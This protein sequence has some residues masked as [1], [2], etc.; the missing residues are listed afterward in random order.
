MLHNKENPCHF[1]LLESTIDPLVFFLR[2]FLSEEFF[3]ESERWVGKVGNFFAVVAAFIFLIIGFRFAIKFDSFNS[4][5]IG[6]GF[7]VGVF[8]IQYISI[9]FV[10]PII[11]SIQNSQTAISDSSFLDII[12][13]LFFLS[14]LGA[15][16]VSIFFA[17]KSDTFNLVIIGFGAFFST[18][19][20]ACLYLNPSLINIVVIESRGPAEDA[21]GVI[22]SF[23]KVTARSVVI[24]Y[25]SW[26]LIGSICLLYATIDVFKGTSNPLELLSY[27]WIFGAGLSYPIIA[28]FSFIF[29]MLSIQLMSTILG[30]LPHLKSIAVLLKNSQN[31]SNSN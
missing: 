2:E 9:K 5:L 7:F 31:N 22:S 26:I 17:V 21:L 20:A 15:L 19:Y 12:A 4:F 16:G 29:S 10:V 28:F 11:T 27:V 13:L 23:I 8:L 3:L 18:S 25:G 6:I 14:G 24:T 30:L 1:T